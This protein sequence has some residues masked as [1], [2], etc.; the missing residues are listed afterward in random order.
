MSRRK[1][2]NLNRPTVARPWTDLSDWVRRVSVTTGPKEVDVVCQDTGVVV[3]TTPSYTWGGQHSERAATFR[4][5]QWMRRHGFRQNFA[6][7]GYFTRV[8]DPGRH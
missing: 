4:A 5:I 1:R 2:P 7:H 3:Y 6:D 8:I